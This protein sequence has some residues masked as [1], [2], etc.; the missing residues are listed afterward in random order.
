[1]ITAQTTISDYIYYLAEDT[2]TP[3][4]VQGTS[5]PM[6][7]QWGLT[8]VQSVGGCPVDYTIY[9][10]DEDDV[11]TAI[12]SFELA[13]IDYI[14]TESINVAIP[15]DQQDTTFDPFNAVVRV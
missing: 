5:R 8:W 1:M 6:D 3:D 12:D 15:W 7:K 11:T 9:V 10:T 14:S 2:T 4:F 13:V